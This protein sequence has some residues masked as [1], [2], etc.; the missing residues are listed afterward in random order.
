MII[1]TK[2]NKQHGSKSTNH[3]HQTWPLEPNEES[4][5]FLRGP[6][7]CVREAKNVNIC[8]NFDLS[9]M[10]F[11]SAA[12]VAKKSLAGDK[13]TAC[14]KQICLLGVICK[15]S[16]RKTL[17]GKTLC[18]LKKCLLSIFQFCAS[19]NLRAADWP[20]ANFRGM[21]CYFPVI[22]LVNFV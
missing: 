19:R 22:R 6:L 12:T 18:F 1:S 11:Q 14:V 7:K 16:N 8:Y 13:I 10:S 5:S 9:R 20:T 21:Y 2:R 4:P 17:S 15:V 3:N